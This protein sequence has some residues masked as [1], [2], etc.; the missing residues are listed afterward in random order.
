MRFFVIFCLFFFLFLHRLPAEEGLVSN[1]SSK[2][3]GELIKIHYDLNGEF[4]KTYKVVLSLSTTNDTDYHYKPKSITGDTGKVTC[5]QNK[6]IIW[7][8]KQ[9][10]P[11]GLKVENLLF[12]VKAK[13]TKNNMLYYLVGGGAAVLGAVAIIVI[14]NTDKT[15]YATGSIAFDVPGDI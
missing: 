14:N 8:F 5:G 10:F 12:N 15:D 3:E 4:D 7:E 11:Q 1:V 9:D 2:Q 13:S 6:E